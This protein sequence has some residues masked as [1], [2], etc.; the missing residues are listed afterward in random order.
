MTSWWG[1]SNIMNKLK[2]AFVAGV[3]TVG[4]VSANATWYTSEAS[5]Q[6]AIAAT[7]YTEDFSNFTF[8]SP[9]SGQTS[10]SAPG[11]NGFGWDASAVSGLYSN[12]SALSTNVA[13]DPLNIT[14]TG[15]AITAFGGLFR[16]TDISGNSI[17]GT[18]TVT[19]TGVGANSVTNATGQAGQFLGWVGNV[20]LTSISILSTSTAT[21]NWPEVDHVIVGNAVPEPATMAV[22]GLGA[23]ALL[24][25][26]RK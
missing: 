3:L 26:R 22:L 24:R 15:A 7:K 17:A 13:N 10:W 4:V 14:N 5:F 11:A 19:I 2:F 12:I 18:T 9:L 1:E 6:A 25:R 8:G 16:N 23:A 21:N 20:S